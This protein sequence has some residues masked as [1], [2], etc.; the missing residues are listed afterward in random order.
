[1]IDD[2]GTAI[3]TNTEGFVFFSYYNLFIS[4]FSSLF[5]IFQE[6]KFPN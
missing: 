6:L 1:M 4:F 5:A 2:T 3:E